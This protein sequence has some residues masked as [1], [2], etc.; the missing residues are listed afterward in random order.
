MVRA[1]SLN[2]AGLCSRLRRWFR[3]PETELL[4]DLLQVSYRAIVGSL[5]LLV[6]HIG[7]CDDVQLV[8]QVVER[9]QS[10]VKH[11]NAVGKLQVVFRG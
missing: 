3:K 4:L 8:A 9:Q 2:F 7:R 10:V 1:C 5:R 6:A 11:E